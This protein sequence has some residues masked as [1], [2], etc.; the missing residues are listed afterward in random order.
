M[1]ERDVWS[2]RMDDIG[3]FTGMSDNPKLSG[4]R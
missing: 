4:T 1:T 2:L 3:M